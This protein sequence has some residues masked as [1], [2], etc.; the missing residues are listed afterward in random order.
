[1]LVCISFI[2]FPP[3]NEASL[4]FEG[5][6]LIKKNIYIYIIYLYYTYYIY[7]YIIYIQARWPHAKN[8]L[9]TQWTCATPSLA[10]DLPDP[11]SVEN[12][13]MNRVRIQLAESVPLSGKA[14]KT[15]QPV[16]LCCN[17]DCYIDVCCLLSAGCW[18]LVAGCWLLACTGWG[19]KVRF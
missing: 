3:S 9:S 19:C 16:A 18:L 17:I 5:L 6:V 8:V 10:S 11:L 2:P 12:M 1:M 15:V 14:A 13:A 7:I 4:L